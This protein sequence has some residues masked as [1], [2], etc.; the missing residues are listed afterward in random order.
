MVVANNNGSHRNGLGPASLSV[1]RSVQDCIEIDWWA[2][3]VLNHTC[4]HLG[5]CGGLV[6]CGHLQG[7]IRV[8][9][10][11]DLLNKFIGAVI[12]Y[13]P[14]NKTKKARKARKAA[15]RKK[16]AAK[17]HEAQGKSA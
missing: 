8:S 5:S 15:R 17:K 9:S 2:H 13:G 7:T 14:K 11:L 16:F 6:Y 4:N 3:L 12:A 10:L 1:G